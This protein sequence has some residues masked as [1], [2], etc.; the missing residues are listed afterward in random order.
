[1]SV[2][3]FLPMGVS[4]LV[5]A[6][7]LEWGLVVWG[8]AH[9]A[10]IIIAAKLEWGVGVWAS[11]RCPAKTS[12]AHYLGIT[13]AAIC[14]ITAVNIPAVNFANSPPPAAAASANDSLVLCSQWQPGTSGKA[15][16][17][18]SGRFGTRGLTAGG[19]GERGE[20]GGS[21][22]GWGCAGKCWCRA[23]RVRGRG[24]GWRDGCRWSSGPAETPLLYDNTI[25]VSW[26]C[27]Q[28][29]CIYL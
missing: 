7:V 26:I 12:L 8:L 9:S 24:G 25:I 10:G 22:R 28:P 20:T 1:V 17:A 29:Q 6:G 19:G 16:S 14:F 13:L 15:G 5:L 18:G 4:A 21:G 23:R 27:G 2:S 3:A 11:R